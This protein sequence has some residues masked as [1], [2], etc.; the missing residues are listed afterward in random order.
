M[1][2]YWGD[3]LYRNEV[4]P[5]V[6]TAGSSLRSLVCAFLIMLANAERAQVYALWEANPVVS[7]AFYHKR[8]K[9]GFACGASLPMRTC[10]ACPRRLR[11]AGRRELRLRATASGQVDPAGGGAAGTTPPRRTHAADTPTVSH[12]L[13]AVAC[14]SSYFSALASSRRTSIP[15]LI[16]SCQDAVQPRLRIDCLPPTCPLS[17]CTLS[18]TALNAFLQQWPPMFNSASVSYVG[19]EAPLFVISP[20][21]HHGSAL[22]TQSRPHFLH[23]SNSLRI[24][25]SPRAR[26]TVTLLPAGF[27]AAFEAVQRV[28]R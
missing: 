13:R 28:W 23:A 8:S 27:D 2:I 15:L 14:V 25:V 1:E 21:S 20:Q 26:I 17:F 19:L 22:P 12:F 16:G 9:K 24:R 6:E 3:A 4:R 18:R 11:A 5:R 7:C 10:C